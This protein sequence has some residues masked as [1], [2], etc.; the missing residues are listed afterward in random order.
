MLK[1]V[2]LCLEVRQLRRAGL[3]LRLRPPETD[4]HPCFC[5]LLVVQNHQVRLLVTLVLPEQV[6]DLIGL[7][8]DCLLQGLVC[9]FEVSDSPVVEFLLTLVLLHLRLEPLNLFLH[10]LVRFLDLL[11]LVMG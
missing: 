6:S 8:L 1:D 4:F 3:E 9:L 2:H 11:H 7:L 5:L 10:R